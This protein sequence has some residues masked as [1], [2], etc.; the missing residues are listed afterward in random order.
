ME[1]NK[2]VYFTESQ[3]KYIKENK[4]RL[5]NE[6]SR[7]NQLL[8]YLEILNKKGNNV[9]LSE[10]KNYLMKKFVTEANIHALSLG[11]NFYL[12]GVARY[13]LNGD[14]TSN[15]QLN[16]FYP[17]VTD[18]FIP[19]ICQRLD[20]IIVY[21]RNAYIDTKGKQFEQPE[22]FGALSIA[23]L[24]KKYGGKV[25]KLKNKGNK[26][27]NV[28]KPKT[29]VSPNVGRDYTFDI[30][31]SQE[32]CK[33]YNQATSPGAWCI[34]YAE[35]HYRYYT[36][37]NNSHF[38]IFKKNDYE[39][40][41]RQVGQGFPLD[42]YG[43]SLLAVQ[44]SNT[45]GS[46]ICCTTRWNHGG[47]GGAPSIPDADYALDYEQLKKITGLSDVQ[48]EGIFKVW[49]ETK[50]KKDG[51]NRAELNAKKLEVT[52]RFKYLEMLF[53]N[54]MTLEEMYERKLINTGK[55]LYPFGKT[56]S[57]VKPSK[58]VFMLEINDNAHN[59]ADDEL[60]NTYMTIM[61]RGEIK[62]DEVLIQNGDIFTPQHGTTY[63][64]VSNSKIPEDSCAVCEITNKKYMFYSYKTHSIIEI[65]GV[66]Y[67]REVT[68]ISKTDYFNLTGCEANQ[69]LIYNFR[70]GRPLEIEGKIIF[71]KVVMESHN[72]YDDNVGH[73][74]LKLVYDS[75]AK[76]IYYYDL[77]SNKIL[78]RL[79]TIAQHSDNT[80]LDNKFNNGELLAFSLTNYGS[81]T[82]S[83]HKDY[84]LYNINTN[85]FV[86]VNGKD[87]FETINKLTETWAKIDSN[88]VN[89]QTFE[90]L[91]YPNGEDV[92]CIFANQIQ[93]NG[94]YDFLE[95]RL[96]EKIDGRYDAYA[97]YDLHTNSFYVNDDG[98]YV[99]K[100][101]GY[102]QVYTKNGNIVNIPKRAD[103]EY[104]YQDYKVENND[105]QR[106]LDEGAKPVDIFDAIDHTSIENLDVV[107]LNGIYN[108][109]NVQEKKLLSPNEWFKEIGN[110]ECGYASVRMTDDKSIIYC[111][112]NYIG[113]DGKLLL[114]ENVLQ[115]F[116]F[117]PNKKTAII[118]SG[119]RGYKVINTEGQIIHPGYFVE[120]Q[121]DN[122]F[123]TQPF[124]RVLQNRQQRNWRYLSLKGHVF[125]SKDDAIADSES[126][127]PSYLE[128]LEQRRREMETDEPAYS[129]NE[130][131]NFDAAARTHYSITGEKLGQYCHVV[132][133]VINE[134]NS[135]FNANKILTKESLDELCSD[136]E[137]RD[138]MQSFDVQK[139]LNYKFWDEDNHLNPRVRMKL[140][141]I[142]DKFYKTM[143]TTWAKPVDVI[144][145][146]SLCNYNW[147][148]YS[149]VDLHVVVDFDE[150]DGRTNFV[151][152]YFDSKKKIWNEA[153]EDLKIYGFPVELYVQDESEEHTASGIYSLYKDEWIVEPNME[154]F[155]ADNLDK[156]MIANKVMS[157]A[158]KIDDLEQQY[159]EE[160]DTHKIEIIGNKVK[161][162][163]DKI[164]GLRKIGLQQEGEMSPKNIL[165][166]SL[167]R[168]GYIAKLIELKAKTFDKMNTIQ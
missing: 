138:V 158:E 121:Q 129:L 57:E 21:L 7:D 23:Q 29:E 62:V 128:Q 130:S 108:V 155:N 114:D 3:I 132:D 70:T 140:L 39:N 116:P 34:T 48:F 84:K 59:E 154:T 55:V 95:L 26:S 139:H 146:G 86:E 25:D 87:T 163:F 135:T 101:Y 111:I 124:Y 68:Q 9:S 41:P 162:L 107:K 90:N 81:N 20:E 74:F 88:I 52:R 35:N 120:I 122:P 149:D 159:N 33:K 51:A 61:D 10:F 133:D 97:L 94:G 67:F 1:N 60:T 104:W 93:K 6:S 153:H 69:E 123:S 56:L 28:E 53:R 117:N 96:G 161:S 131:R 80:N 136:E 148:K 127:N 85:N 44:Q 125:L 58:A 166:K 43:L 71:E 22:D 50:P 126:N 49:Q 36:K 8:P 142:A 15:K 134:L 144:F 11:S 73:V 98:S 157:C 64:N 151:K 109:L 100:Y 47:H 89:M 147:S 143:E 77:T 30:M 27:A 42:E 38:V 32:D 118:D 4:D 83:W 72:R 79:T 76:E 37:H 66:K 54:G 16:I 141:E 40:I 110:F 31:Y 13:Y 82:Y 150:V 113:V 145:T 46:F 63:N 137:L 14:L 119:H 167:R 165:F 152:D 19:E 99:F 91:K 24:F 103:G 102:G 115:A 106:L 160:T 168:L 92:I 5:L 105:V 156:K 75:A 78:E 2:K 112:E 65:D 17:R 164:K 18:R 45:D 12:V